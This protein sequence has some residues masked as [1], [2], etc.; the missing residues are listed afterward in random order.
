MPENNKVGCEIPALPEVP[1]SRPKSRPVLGSLSQNRQLPVNPDHS[2]RTKIHGFSDFPE[3]PTR[4]DYCNGNGTCYVA[5][6]E[7]NPKP[8][9]LTPEEQL[10]AALENTST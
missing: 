9:Q 7:T 5:K 2:G 1:K 3:D 8:Q 4:A 10:L 6:T